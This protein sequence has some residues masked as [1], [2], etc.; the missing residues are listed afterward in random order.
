MLAELECS[1]SDTTYGCCIKQHPEEPEKCGGERPPPQPKGPSC[2]PY[3]PPPVVRTPEQSAGPRKRPKKKPNEDPDGCVCI[4]GPPKAQFS[5]REHIGRYVEW[6]CRSICA[7]D[8]GFDYNE[9]VCL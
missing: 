9:Y 7:D 5:E 1:P 2:P 3:C 4:C 6:R 8:Y